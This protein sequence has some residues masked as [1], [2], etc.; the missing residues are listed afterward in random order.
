MQ[1]PSSPFAAPPSLP[2]ARTVA[3]AYSAVRAT[4]Q[5]QGADAH[6]LVAMLFRGLQDALNEARG[7]LQRGDVA[8]KCSALSRAA[9]IVD[10]GLKASLNLQEGGEIAQNLHTLY[11]Y[12]SM[13]L[14]KANLR[15]DLR[16][17]EE[18]ANLLDPVQ[19]AWARIAR[20][21]PSIN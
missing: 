17:V 8:L 9:R 4:T 15:S 21:T 12:M 13:T 7:A 18:V 2:A 3:H 20:S 10:E 1:R 16:L 5:L 14:T 19:D 11:D 6:Q